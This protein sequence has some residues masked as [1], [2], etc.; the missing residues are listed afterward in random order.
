MKKLKLLTLIIGV[1]FLVF[2]CN[3]DEILTKNENLN[4]RL[5]AIESSIISG[6][7]NQENFFDPFE[8]V[9]LNFF[10][11]ISKLNYEEENSVE[12]ILSE[13]NQILLK[14]GLLTNTKIDIDNKSLSVIEETI[15]KSYVKAL[16][17]N[18]ENSKI[19][20]AEY[21]INEISKLD[22]LSSESRNY[23]IYAIGLHKN[24]MIFVNFEDDIENKSLVSN[25]DEWWTPCSRR[26]CLD[27]CMYRKSQAM[28]DWNWV[29]WAYFMTSP[30]ANVAAWAASCGWDCLT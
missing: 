26:P 21:Y 30:A 17:L 28:N 14:S 27:C 5:A 3:K 24:L 13:N 6:F 8:M 2:S 7:S 23:C 29:D 12:S 22:F 20:V 10:N 1:V 19:K 25:Y 9:H 15:L 4:E 16:K 18:K 11:N